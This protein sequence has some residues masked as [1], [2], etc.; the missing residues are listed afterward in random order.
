MT[1][2][3]RTLCQL[4]RHHRLIWSSSLPGKCI[5]SCD[6]V[7]FQFCIG[8]VQRSEAFNIPAYSSLSKLFSLAK[9]PLVLVSFLNWRCT[10]S[11]ALV[12]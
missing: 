12:V 8:W 9:P 4:S 7:R 1:R 11:T 3:F 6:N 10:A 5:V 2:V